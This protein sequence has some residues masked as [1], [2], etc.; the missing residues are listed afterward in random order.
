MV[1]AKRYPA[2][3]KTIEN[4]GSQVQRDMLHAIEANLEAPAKKL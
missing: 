3:V 4:E 1:V 2:V